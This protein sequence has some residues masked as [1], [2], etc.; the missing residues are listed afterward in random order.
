M[1][2]DIKLTIR[3]TYEF[4]LEANSLEEA[5]KQITQNRHCN[6]T[7]DP[8]FY[9]HYEARS[10]GEMLDTICVDGVAKSVP[11][12]ETNQ[13]WNKLRDEN[14]PELPEGQVY[15]LIRSYCHRPEDELNQLDSIEEE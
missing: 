9:K 2:Y 14:C 12:K 6:S 4:S 11:D 7:D 1:Q 10:W 3:D 15:L 5:L 13:M 8:S